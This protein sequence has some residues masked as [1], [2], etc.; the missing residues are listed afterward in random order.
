MAAGQAKIAMF[1]AFM[2]APKRIVGSDQSPNF[3]P[4]YSRHELVAKYPLEVGG[5]LPGA[6]FTVTANLHKPQPFF[7][8]QILFPASVCRLDYTDEHHVNALRDP[9]DGIG[10]SMTGPHYHSWLI[11]KRFYHTLDKPIELHNAVPLP[12]CGRTFDAVLRWFCTDTKI[13]SLPS[14]HRIELPVRETLF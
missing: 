13:D 4:G 6:H 7:R 12:D 9:L 1:D 2:G 3:L 11:N 8:L 5:E 10:W 14:N